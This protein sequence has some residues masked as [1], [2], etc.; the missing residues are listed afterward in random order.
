VATENQ[1]QSSDKKANPL[2]QSVHALEEMGETSAK[3]SPIIQKG[4]KPL[5]QFLIKSLNDWIMNLQAGALAYSL[6]IAF[7]PI[8]IALLSLFGFVL[9][10][11]G[12]AAKQAL[13]DAIQRALPNQHDVANGVIAAINS[14]QLSL[15]SGP[16]AIIALLVAIIGGSRL[17]IMMENCFALIY[18]QRPRPFLQQNLMAIGMLVLFAVLIPLMV[19]ASSIPPIVLTFLQRSVLQILPGGGFILSLFSILGSLLVS[20]I[21]FEALYII[22]PRPH[23]RFSK[24]WRGALFA[25]IALQIYL[26]LFPLYATHFLNSYLGQV[27]FALILIVFFYYFA[28]ILLLGAQV[29][30]FF[31][32][33]IRYTPDNL[34]G[35]VHEETRHKAPPPQEHE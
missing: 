35:M 6:L 2:E 5:L 27:G 4:I 13:T 19:V 14:K 23:I 22:V 17:F 20:W 10:G 29:N 16:L 34:A 11:Q 8:T 3:Q 21:L 7:F 1:Q 12:Q 18:H 9:G 31:T 15:A 24:S 28:V 30:A 26:S 32:E 25:S 33:G